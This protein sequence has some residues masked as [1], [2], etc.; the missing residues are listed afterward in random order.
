MRQFYLIKRKKRG[1]E[2]QIKYKWFN[3][4]NNN[5]NNNNG[6]MIKIIISLSRYIQTYRLVFDARI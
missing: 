3:N 5:N 6:K 2:K 1:K 4:N